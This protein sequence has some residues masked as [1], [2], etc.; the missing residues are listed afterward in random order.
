[1]FPLRAAR[2]TFTPDRHVRAEE[3]RRI[4]AHELL[5][6]RRRSAAEVENL[7]SVALMRPGGAGR[8]HDISRARASFLC[9]LSDAHRR[10]SACGSPLT[11]TAFLLGGGLAV[12]RIGKGEAVLPL[13]EA[14]GDYAARARTLE[15][16]TRQP[17][18]LNG[19]FLHTEKA[20]GMLAPLETVEKASGF[21]DKGLD[22]GCSGGSV[23]RSVI[24]CDVRK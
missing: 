24:S 9:R 11:Q 7:L 22:D 1:M 23:M 18:S 20:G 12:L 16:G 15:E 13:A 19:F 2:W 21:F 3:A 5:R 14:G 6:P 8:H 17:I 10:V 4:C